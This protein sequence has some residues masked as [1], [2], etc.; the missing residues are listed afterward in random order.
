MSFI[1]SFLFQV[2]PLFHCWRANRG[3]KLSHTLRTSEN[4]H[5]HIYSL[6]FK[7]LAPPFWQRSETPKIIPGTVLCQKQS[8]AVSIFVFEKDITSERKKKYLYN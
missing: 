8:G 1:L 5:L 2:Q 6:R 3:L 4:N 7:L